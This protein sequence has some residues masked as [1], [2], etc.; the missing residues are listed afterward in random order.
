MKNFSPE[1]VVLI[2]LP[3]SSSAAPNFR[4]R[5]ARSTADRL[6]GRGWWPVATGSVL[7]DVFPLYVFDT[8]KF[9]SVKRLRHDAANCGSNGVEG[10]GS[11]VA[12]L[13]RVL[14]AC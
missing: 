5:I 7:Q 8:D 3:K 14:G 10:G 13:R 12:A 2:R 1:R 11:V 6:A 4:R 9:V